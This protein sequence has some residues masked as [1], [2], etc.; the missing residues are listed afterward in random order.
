MSIVLGHRGAS[1]YAPEN[2]LEA[3][4]LAMDMGA[5]GFELDVHLSKDGEL[6]VI[7]DET[8]DRTTDGTG[9]VGEMTLAELKALDA[10]NHKEG[11][12]GAKIP[13]LGEVYDLIR[14]TDHIVNVEIKTDNIFYPQLEEKVLALE[15]EKGMEGR[16]VYSSFN[17]YT[18]K[19]IR[20]LAPDAQIG[21]LFGDVLVEPYDYCKSVGANLLH[22]S[23]ANLNVPGFAEKAK[24]AGLGMNVWTVNEVEYMEKCLACGAGIVTN[25]PDIAV[26]LRNK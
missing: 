20:T 25:Y 16:I 19:K 1:G 7:H 9:F 4:K 23:K 14:D 12:K 22:P 11:Y 5:D 6:V 8:V 13:T 3:F 15:K 2:T 17:H 24:E 26:K 21:M 10:S 18:V